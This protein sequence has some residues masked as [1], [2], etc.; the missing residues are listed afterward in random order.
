M[1][2]ESIKH[3]CLYCVLVAVAFLGYYN[4]SFLSITVTMW[5][6]LSAKVFSEQAR[7]MARAFLIFLLFLLV[8]SLTQRRIHLKPEKQSINTNLFAGAIATNGLRYE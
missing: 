4:F 7:E 5:L 3:H 1:S 2:P 6:V 8:A